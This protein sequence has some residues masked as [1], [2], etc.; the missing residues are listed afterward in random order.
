[1]WKSFRKVHLSA[2]I[3]LGFVRTLHWTFHRRTYLLLEFRNK[4]VGEDCARFLAAFRSTAFRACFIKAHLDQVH[5]G[6]YVSHFCVIS[7]ARCL[8]QRGSRDNPIWMQALDMARKKATFGLF[9]AMFF[10]YSIFVHGFGF[11]VTKKLSFE[12]HWTWS[13]CMPQSTL[14]I[15]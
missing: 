15:Q 14:L 3:R 4:S 5:A 6:T 2:S 8:L 11:N 9:L 13:L 7:K 1:M 12:G 10:L